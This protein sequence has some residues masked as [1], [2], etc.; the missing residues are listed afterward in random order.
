MRAGITVVA[1][2]LA[3][4][5]TAVPAQAAPHLVIGQGLNPG[6]AVDAAGTAYVGWQVN[7]LSDTGDTVQLCVLPAKARA[8]A[9]Q[10]T[11]AFPGTGYQVGRVSVLLPAP[12]VV[13]VAVGRNVQNVYG[14]YL[15]T[16]TDGGATFGTPIRIGGDFAKRAALLPGG[17]IAAEGDDVRQ[18]AGAVLRPDGSDASVDGPVLSNRAQFSDI[19]VEGSD[20]YI[21]GSLAG[22]TTV[23]RLPAGANYA[24]P[25]AWQ[26]LPEL[27]GGNSP[28]LAP[29]PAGPA[30]MLNP[31]DPGKAA[32]SVQHWT[33]A[34][35]TPLVTIGPDNAVDSRAIAGAGARLIGAW[36]VTSPG[37]GHRVEFAMSLDGGALWSSVSTMA[38]PSEASYG[39]QTAITPAGNG[40]VVSGGDGDDAPIEVFVVDPHRAKVAR[41]RFGST[42]VQLRADEGD[43]VNETHLSLRIQAARG[44]LLVSPGTVLKRA[45][46]SASHS[47]VLHRSRWATLVDLRSQR[48][49]RT[50]TVRLVPR[51]GHT[52]RLRLP[53]RACGHVA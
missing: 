51:H 49:T 27:P 48:A 39:L 44:G 2:A 33:G 42:T 18:L 43:C 15:A 45:R 36:S 24:D 34:A 47:R 26:I 12:G 30:V 46:I 20:I 22:P 32:P 38:V 31:N 17:L 16:S 14:Y 11:I 41:A 13:E 8:C 3:A 6:V 21:A 40:V 9:A 37:P 19:T 10:P 7:T 35:W 53:V 52:R 5:L 29:G 50:A 4:A 25:A 1:A 28:K 23:A